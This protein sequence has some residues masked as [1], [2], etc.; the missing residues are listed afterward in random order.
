MNSVLFYFTE[1][2]VHDGS[3]V[4]KNIIFFATDGSLVTL[5]ERASLMASVQGNPHPPRPAPPRLAGQLECPS[6]NAGRRA[7]GSLGS[8]LAPEGVQKHVRV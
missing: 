5:A 6:G 7:L 1:V 8:G 3:V 2:L 4:K